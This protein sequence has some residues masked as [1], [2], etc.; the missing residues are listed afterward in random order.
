M[1]YKELISQPYQNSKISAGLTNDSVDVVYLKLERDGEEPTI[2]HL[3]ADEMLAILY[4]ASGCLW[5]ELLDQY[6]KNESDSRLAISLY[7]ENKKLKAA[8]EK[9]EECEE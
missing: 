8:L 1:K 4:C 9:M 7:K 6:N 2:I 5:S 3:R